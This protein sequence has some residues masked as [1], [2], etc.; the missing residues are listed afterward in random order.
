MDANRP[1]I[2]RSGSDGRLK[3]FYTVHTK[4]PERRRMTPEEI[5]GAVIELVSRNPGISQ[6]QVIEE[7][8]IDRDTVGYHLRALVGEEALEA[9][10]RGRYTVYSVNGNR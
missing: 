8:G 6:L 5:R 9:R 1:C 3:R 7:L 2:I 4:V 10:R